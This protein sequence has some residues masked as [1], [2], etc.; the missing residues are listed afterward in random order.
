MWVAACGMA[1][2]YLA[3]ALWLA[4]AY[5]PTWDGVKGE[6]RWGE[7]IVA[8]LASGERD[9]LDRPLE[10]FKLT[11]REPHPDFRGIDFHWYEF[12][13]LSAMLS[14]ASEQVF[15]TRL[16]WIP[17]LVAYHLVIMLFVALLALVMVRFFG[18][19]LGLSVGAAS[20]LFLLLSPRF[21]AHSFNSLRDMPEACLYALTVMAG[22]LALTRT[23][24]RWWEGPCPN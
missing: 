5:G 1:A 6:Y 16:G 17:P 2:G 23:R 11:H 13:P 8:Y 12:W 7:C 9:L 24:L 22:Y 19:R 20:A 14:S 4:P 3:V 15:W 21:F 18:R 10:R